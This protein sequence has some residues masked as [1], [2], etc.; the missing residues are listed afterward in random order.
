MKVEKNYFL[1]KYDFLFFKVLLWCC[2]GFCFLSFSILIPTISYNTIKEVVIFL[3]LVLIVNAHTSYLY[4]IISKKSKFYYYVLL[5]TSI[6]ICVLLEMLIFAKSFNDVYS[7]MDRRK[8]LLFIA[9][10]ITIRDAAFFVFFFCVEY[11]NRLIL[12]YKEKETI[13][14]KEMALLVEKQEFEKKFSR[15]KLLPHYFFNILEHINI[16]VLSNDTNNELI[17]K[18]KFILYYFLV[19]AEKEKIQ[20][21]KELT[22]YKYYIELEKFRYKENI[23]VNLNFLG[24]PDDYEIIPL[25]FE[26]LINN[27]MKYT[28]HNGTG[29]VNIIIDA[30]QFPVLKFSCRNNYIQRTSNIISSENGLKILEQR[31]DLCYNNKHYLSITQDDDVY[32]VLLSVD[33]S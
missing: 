22:F 12:L 19:D 8:M 5:I 20:L 24:K 15:K 11:F 25:L 27:A 17:D 7:F 30:L 2:V 28:K 3:I 4:Q 23:S 16:D 33:I 1:K 31:L 6:L 9:I 29:W 32:E 14:K 21:E 26:P 10:Y 18:V 13:H